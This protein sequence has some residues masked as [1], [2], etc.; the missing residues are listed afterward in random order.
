MD[1]TSGSHEPYRG[2]YFHDP[3]VGSSTNDDQ[4]ALANQPWQEHQTKE[5]RKY[6]YHKETKQSSWEMPEAYRDA[7]AQTEPPTPKSA[8]P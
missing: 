3:G 8:M 4:R 5:G 6:W 2:Q 1:E 7:L